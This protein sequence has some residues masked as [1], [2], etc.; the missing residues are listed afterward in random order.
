MRIFEKQKQHLV[1]YMTSVLNKE[2]VKEALR[3]LIHEEPAVFKSI[4]KEILSEEQDSEFE[5]LLLKNF[6]RFDETFRALA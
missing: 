1:Y 5:T 4:L 2:L 6:D 3:E